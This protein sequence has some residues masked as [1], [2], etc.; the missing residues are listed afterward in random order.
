M[1]FFVQTPRKP[2]LGELLGGGIGR[3]LETGMQAQ[4]QN[5]MQQRAF[6]QRPLTPYQELLTVQREKDLQRKVGNYIGSVLKT[7]IV[8]DVSPLEKARID[9]EAYSLVEQ[10]V[11]LPSAAEQSIQNFLTKR[12]AFEAI[13]LPKPS[14]IGKNISKKEDIAKIFTE[15]EI[16]NP[17]DIQSIMKRKGW[18][19]KDIQ[20]VYRM[21]R[22]Q[23]EKEP[24]KKILDETAK[25]EQPEIQK[26]KFDSKNP[27]HVKKAR[28]A[29]V[30]ANGDRS[31]A[32][33][34]LSREFTL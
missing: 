15:N 12:E 30:S 16:M 18:K 33:K 13:E 31:I 24:V 22:T 7:D 34:I 1:S 4:L 19:G 23:S 27:E 25:V 6:G 32:N 20:D 5:I 29:L 2:S 9:K 28:E 21:V 26:V 8:A 17:A 10:G 14:R 3:G 11:D